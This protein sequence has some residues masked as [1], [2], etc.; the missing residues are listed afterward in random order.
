M[1]QRLGIAIG[2]GLMVAL[3]GCVAAT[4]Y[5]AGFFAYQPSLGAPL[6]RFDDWSL[7]QPL[8]YFEWKH[9]AEDRFP[10]EFI[11][12]DVFVI[13]GGALGAGASAWVLLD[14]VGLA[15]PNHAYRQASRGEMSGW[16]G[17]LAFPAIAGLAIFTAC[18][19]LATM[20]I[21]MK[22]DFHP[23]L[24][25]PI[26]TLEGVKLYWPFDF[27]K[28]KDQFERPGS[29]DFGAAGVIIFMGFV[30]GA[31]MAVHLLRD[32]GGPKSEKVEI[33]GDGGFAAPREIKAAGLIHDG[34][35]MVLGRMRSFFKDQLLVYRGE[36]H[37]LCF[38]GTRTGKGRG[39]VIPTCLWWPGSLVVLDP[40][41]ELAEGDPRLGFAGTAGH[42][43]Q[44]SHV[45]RFAPMRADSARFNPLFEVRKNRNDVRDVQNIVDILTAQRSEGA[46]N[47][48]WRA[49]SSTLL[50]GV[51]LD[52]LYSA[53]LEHKNL[54]EVRRR[55]SRMQETAE[56]MRSRLHRRNENTGAWETH[57]YVREAADSF[58]SMEERTQSNVRATAE[59][60]VAIFGDP[61]TA[62]NT[63][64]SDFRLADLM[65]NAH[66]VT[67]YIEFPTSDAAKSMPVLQMLITQIMRSLTESRTHD[68][69]GRQKRHKV[70]LLL[71]EFQQL[72]RIP[73]FEQMLSLMAGYSI[74]VM[75]VCQTLNAIRSVYGQNNTI[76]D[77]CDIITSFA[78]ADPDTAKKI[79]E[80]A[81]EDYFR[82]AQPT[83]HMG[84][85]FGEA[86][87]NSITI[88]EER[89]SLLLPSDVMRLSDD[90]MLIFKMGIK[91]IR[92]QKV[93]YDEHPKLRLLPTPSQIEQTRLTTSHDWQDQTT[94]GKPRSADS[95]VAPVDYA[96][97]VPKVRKVA[98]EPIQPTLFP[99]GGKP[100]S[101]GI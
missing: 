23:A 31:A 50:T 48:F 27:F 1:E 30:F 51:I 54:A 95:P 72:G 56:E 96:K 59:T 85:K 32:G 38:G 89:R 65:G 57:P 91:P 66:P 34:F 19:F 35:G 16:A 37:V 69:L 22:F 70:L 88:R 41:G 25:K 74:Q 84:Q 86:D 12:G 8:H 98:P 5:I 67:L 75:M 18:A 79:S 80:R 28:W 63:S 6:L 71:E 78:A 21:A 10:K 26:M 46:D 62:E 76:L 13:A 94:P 60:Y 45:L 33:V 39:I 68:S 9:H 92:A 87:R 64:T 7:Y 17:R 100:R 47:E 4:Q 101:K 43:S 77:N 73:H 42:R 11:W 2:A 40:K 58:L 82:V 99:D 15:S 29:N 24:G 93:R 20:M 52:V 49:S 3:L 90:Q 36:G 81:G 61:L 83:R 44:F 14:G 97:F 53:P 55:L